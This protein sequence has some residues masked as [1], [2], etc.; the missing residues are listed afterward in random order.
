MMKHS[1]PL[2]WRPKPSWIVARWHDKFSTDAW[3]TDT[4][5]STHHEIWS[6]TAPPGEFQRAD[7]YSRK[8]WR[9]VQFLVNEFW[10]RWRKDYLQSLQPRQKWVAT[11]RNLQVDDIVIIKDDNPPRNCWKLALVEETYP[12]DNDNN[13][14]WTYCAQLNMR[15]ISCA[16]QLYYFTRSK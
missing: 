1:E 7:L 5:L 14:M 9:T 6:D 12:D 4:Q 3:A 2:W 11:R 8:R 15:M 16:L 13:N 10:V